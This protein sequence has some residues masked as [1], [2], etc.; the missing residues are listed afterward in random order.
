MDL[1]PFGTKLKWTYPLLQQNFVESSLEL[2]ID[3][4]VAQTWVFK[5]P[6]NGH[7]TSD[8]WYPT[9]RFYAMV[10]KT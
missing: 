2:K 5:V 8:F 7:P 4:L 1:T 10:D 3:V 9:F 6:Q